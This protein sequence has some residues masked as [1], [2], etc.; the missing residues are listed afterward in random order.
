MGAS[1]W[2]LQACGHLALQLPKYGYAK[3]L[4]ALSA[5]AQRKRLVW[6]QQTAAMSWV[7]SMHDC[8][9]SK[10]RLSGTRLP[11]LRRRMSWVMQQDSWLMW[12]GFVVCEMHVS[13]GA[14]PLLREGGAA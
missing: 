3:Q 7:M 11:P 5:A 8:A 4:C 2:W 1:P 13:D 6:Q 10:A 14:R 9:F 12:C